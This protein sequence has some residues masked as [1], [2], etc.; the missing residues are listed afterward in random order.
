MKRINFN[1]IMTFVS[2]L[3]ALL[4][5]LTILTPTAFA[6]LP[7][8]VK[9]IEA[10]NRREHIRDPEEA[11]ALGTCGSAQLG[12]INSIFMIGDSITEGADSEL[13]QKLAESGAK[14]V[15]DG[16]SSRRLSTGD[17]DTDGLSIIEKSVEE[18][19]NAEVVVIA[20]GTNS[21]LTEANIT[22]AI[23]AVRVINEEATIF[24]VNV[25]AD[26]T[27]RS[28][29]L[30]FTTWNQTLKT[31]ADEQKFFV[32]DWSA[33]INKVIGT[34][35]SLEYIRDDGLGVH[36]NDAGN[37]LFALTI[38]QALYSSSS[39]GGCNVELSGGDNPEKVWNY[40]IAKG[41]QPFQVAGFMGNMQA[42]A[43]FEPRRLEYAFS[44]PPHLSTSVPP[45]AN[46][47]CQPG[48]GIVQWTAKG[49]K[50][51]LTQHIQ[52]SGIVVTD[53]DPEEEAVNKLLKLQL[54]FVW[55]EIMGG[56]CA[57][58]ES[59]RA[60]YGNVTV[61]EALQQTK[62]VEEATDLILRN[63]EIPANMDAA[64]RVRI[65]FA[66]AW[67]VRFDSGGQ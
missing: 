60:R 56:C 63:Y 42:E 2:G 40:M 65:D 37:V 6:V 41:L 38:Y 46:D 66:R 57:L 39:A 31:M 47:K 33:A 45:C 61:L 3:L 16:V 24:W 15:I 50:D 29:D 53:L 12:N 54:D 58:K 52:A 28:S 44:S 8:T 32:I 21:G 5:F 51:A 13:Q 36:P 7:I 18:I 30:D 9:D 1:S 55:V 43:G 23:E 49:R 11:V 19:E 25:Y 14:V 67:L 26:N 4:I 62:D 48:W 17:E 64:Y 34:G 22:D 10:I 59:F 27:L 35:S 20:L